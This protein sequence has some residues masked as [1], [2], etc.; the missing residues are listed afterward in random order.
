M[1][2][3]Y[4]VTFVC[5]QV[6]LPRSKILFEFTVHDLKEVIDTGKDST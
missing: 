3:F 4:Y 1:R 2:I 5:I 6:E